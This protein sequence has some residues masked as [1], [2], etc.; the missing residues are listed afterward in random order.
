M[1]SLL[2]LDLS[3]I[4][5]KKNI[6]ILSNPTCF[7]VDSNTLTNVNT[8]Q[9]PKRRKGQNK[10]TAAARRAVVGTRK[11]KEDR[12]AAQKTKKIEEATPIRIKKSQLFFSS[13]FVN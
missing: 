8:C 6:S 3:C 9:N 11:K 5:K 1:C 13:V 12:K 4:L 7:T 2:I 10:H